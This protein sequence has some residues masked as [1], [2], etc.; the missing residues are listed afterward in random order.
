MKNL[1]KVLKQISTSFAVAIG[2]ARFS[3]NLNNFSEILHQSN[4]NG[5]QTPFTEISESLICL[6]LFSLVPIDLIVCRTVGQTDRDSY[7]SQ[8]VD[9]TNCQVL[10]T[11]LRRKKRIFKFST[12]YELNRIVQVCNIDSSIACYSYCAWPEVCL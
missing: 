8:L 10:L 6:F 1:N 7:G 4:G 2:L 5:A 11:N 9:H 3:I 12:L